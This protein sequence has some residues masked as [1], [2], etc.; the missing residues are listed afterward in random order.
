MGMTYDQF[1]D[2]DVYAHKAF[3]QAK[4]VRLAEQNQIAWLQGQYVYDAISALASYMKAFSKAKPKPYNKEPYDLFAEE[5]RRREEREARE[6]YERIRSK[7]AEFAS[8]FNERRK[9]IEEN[10]GVDDDA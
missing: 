5:R 2:G 7:V 4:K 3:R 1:W 8:A 10:K 9:Q 6:R